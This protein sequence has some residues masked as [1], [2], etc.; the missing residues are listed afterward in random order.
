MLGR[1]PSI[2]AAVNE[3]VARSAEQPHHLDKKCA[4]SSTPLFSLVRTHGIP[5]GTIGVSRC[6]LNLNFNFDGGTTM[7]GGNL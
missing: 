2:P 5:D 6:A 7:Q 4:T 3:L 1:I